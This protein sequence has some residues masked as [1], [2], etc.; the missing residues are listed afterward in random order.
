MRR[1]AE[2]VDQTRQRITEAAV[3]LHTT[4]GPAHTSIASVAEAAG[5]TR[6]TVYR[7]FGDMD[8][9][10][11]A[12]RAH[13]LAQDPP[14]DPAIWMTEVDVEA[15]ARLAFGQLY[16]WYRERGEEL[17]PIARDTNALPATAQ[18]ARAA[19]NRRLGDA[20]V[21]DVAEPGADQRRSLRAVARH[22]TD[23]MTWRSL[24]VSHGLEDH[25]AVEVAVRML[26]AVAGEAPISK[27]GRTRRSS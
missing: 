27:R 6:L 20:I 11:Q 16:R 17:Y 14:P 23:F 19:D 12:C 9:L 22:L 1:R 24:V 18:Q 13:W 26:M 7:H 8:A 4:V 2:L 25:E 5:V 10:F 15:R 3:R 21:G